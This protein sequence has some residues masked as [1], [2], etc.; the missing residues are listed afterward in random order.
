MWPLR[1]NKFLQEY[2]KIIHIMRVYMVWSLFLDMIAKNE[3]C[4]D[5]TV[6]PD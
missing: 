6:N 2:F 3:T 4:E 1:N 5:S